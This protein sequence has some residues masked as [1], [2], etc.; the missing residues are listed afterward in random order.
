MKKKRAPE[1]ADDLCT[2]TGILMRRKP[3]Q[4]YL[5]KAE[6]QHIYNQI[7]SLETKLASKEKK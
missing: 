6:M 5:S 7:T 4:V 2:K 3:G 1:I